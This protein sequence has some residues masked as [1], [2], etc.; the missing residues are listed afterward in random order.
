MGELQTLWTQTVAWIKTHT[1]VVYLLVA[2]VAAVFLLPKL[3]KHLFKR[4]TVR[5]HY[6]S[7]APRYSFAR[8]GRSVGRGKGSLYMRRKMARLRA[9][10][11]RKRR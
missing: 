4:R 10:R 7:Y 6:R 11:R 2:A 8:R 1:K 5:H 9:L 3:Y